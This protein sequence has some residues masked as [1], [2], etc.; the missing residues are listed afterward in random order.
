[1]FIKTDPKYLKLT[2]QAKVLDDFVRQ[3]GQKALPLAEG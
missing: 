2:F 3:G 1:M